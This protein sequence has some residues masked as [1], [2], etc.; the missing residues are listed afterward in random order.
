MSFIGNLLLP[1][2]LALLLLVTG[3]LA[4][5][6]R[7]SQPW[8][9]KL[10]V[11]G[12]L[13]ALVFSLGVVARLLLNPLE[14]RYPAW[15]PGVS[16]ALTIDHIVLLTAW[17]GDNPDLP[18]GVRLNDSSASRA[19]VTMQLW[20]LHPQTTV[21][22]S[23]DERNARD[24]GEV[25]L[26]LGLPADRLRLETQSRNTGDSALHVAPLLDGKPFALVT[27]AGHLPRSM[28]T[29]AK[30]GLDALPVPADFR[31]P[32]PVSA[33]SFLPAPRALQASDLAVHE[34]L[35]LTWYRML[36]RL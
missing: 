25:L 33:A 28:A 3:L 12:A 5:S 19:L 31:L 17:A 7:R 22:V 14:Q 8:S 4:R 10:L 36:G 24:L 21:I 20:R 6:S 9:G 1:S 18:A 30:A 15:S 29:F 34:Y 32:G 13:V 26:T 35:G 16:P 27:S 11:A 2:H 23:G